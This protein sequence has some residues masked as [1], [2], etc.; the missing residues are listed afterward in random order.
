VTASPNL[1]MEPSINS[2]LTL[3]VSP[4]QDLTLPLLKDIGW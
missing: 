1:L 3:S 4:P 2:D